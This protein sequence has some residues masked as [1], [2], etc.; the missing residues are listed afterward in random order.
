VVFTG[1]N[2]QVA[3]DDIS[4]L[5]A[6]PEPPAWLAQAIGLACVCLCLSMRRR[7]TAVGRRRSASA[8]A[9]T[10]ARTAASP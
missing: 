8:L 5:T 3:I 9:P 1:G 2:D 6:V 7:G 4:F 10:E